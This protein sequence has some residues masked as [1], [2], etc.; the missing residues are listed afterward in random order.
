MIAMVLLVCMGGCECYRYDGELHLRQQ[1]QNTFVS[2]KEHEK[3][4]A[5]IREMLD[6]ICFGCKYSEFM[7]GFR[8]CESLYYEMNFRESEEQNETDVCNVDW[9][10]VDDPDGW[11]VPGNVPFRSP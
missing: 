7:R 3:L 10:D 11:W 5:M 8:A 4:I 6:R 2:E 1:A 9:F